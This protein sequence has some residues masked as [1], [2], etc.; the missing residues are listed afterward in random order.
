VRLAVG[1]VAARAPRWHGRRVRELPRR[2]LAD[3]H[4]AYW[5]RN[6]ERVRRVKEYYDLVGVYG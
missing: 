6:L 3:E 5:R 1:L 2:D 4:R